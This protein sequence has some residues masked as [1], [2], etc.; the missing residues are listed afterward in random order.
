MYARNI[1]E[2][3]EQCY[4]PTYLESVAMLSIYLSFQQKKNLSSLDFFL[5]SHLKTPVYTF[6]IIIVYE[7]A[8]LILE[9]DN[10]QQLNCVKKKNFWILFH[11]L[12]WFDKFNQ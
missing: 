6:T 10:G 8:I 1:L 9:K 3:P 11:T 2:N 5:R 7:N 12:D 4:Y